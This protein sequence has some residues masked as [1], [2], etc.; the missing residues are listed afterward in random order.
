MTHRPDPTTPL[1][2]VARD[3]ERW[4]LR[5]VRDL[6]HPPEKVWRALTES[7]HLRHWMPADLVGERRTGA[8]LSIPFWPDTVEKYGL[9]DPPLSGVVVVWDPPRVFVWTWDTDRLRFELEATAGG[10]RLTFTTWLVEGAPS[11][12]LRTAAGWHICLDLLAWRLGGESGSTA[13]AVPAPFEA[14]YSEAYRHLA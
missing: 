11:V 3:G 12:D 2:E 1:G 4:R 9:T 13:E 8:A 6:R 10:T 7:E 14:I 5:Y